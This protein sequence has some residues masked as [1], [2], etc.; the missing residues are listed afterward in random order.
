VEGFRW[1]SGVPVPEPVTAP[2]GAFA[3]ADKFALDSVEPVVVV[4]DGPVLSEEVVV[5]DTASWA[6]A[7]DRDARK[8]RAATAIR[9][10]RIVDLV[11]RLL[12]F[13]AEIK[14]MPNQMVATY[15][16]YYSGRTANNGFVHL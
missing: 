2:G 4:E 15:T 7:V 13:P 12:P 6:V 8:Q 3:G 9:K 5:V 16:G 14:Q 10:M 1:T 11:I